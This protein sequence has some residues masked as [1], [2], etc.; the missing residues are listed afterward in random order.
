MIT[1]RLR[2]LAGLALAAA[3]L[4][5]APSSAAEKATLL[6]NSTTDDVWN[7]QMGLGIARKYVDA[8]GGPAAVLLDVRAVALANRKVPQH[9]GALA[10]TDF[11]TLLR[12]L[13]AKGVKVY[14]CRECTRRAGLST[15][16][17]L[18]GAEIGGAALLELLVDPKTNVPGY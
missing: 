2:P 7:Y 12:E 5:A 6:V 15:D 4:A 17:R 9:I 10:Q 8:T 1:P 3:I 13:V 16:D 14:V 18:E 11:Q